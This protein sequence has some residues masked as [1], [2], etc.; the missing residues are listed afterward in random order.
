MKSL[1]VISFLFYSTILIS[2]V[3][4]IPKYASLTARAKA[5]E[6]RIEKSSGDS[7]TITC[8]PNLY[9][10]DDKTWV[11]TINSFNIKDT[12]AWIAVKSLNSGSTDTCFV[13]IVPWSANLSSLDIVNF[14][15]EKYSIIGKDNNN[16]LY[17]VYNSKLYKTEKG[18]N[19]LE[20]L[21]NFKLNN[22]EYHA[23]FLKTP[24]GSF[25]R[26]EKD[27]YFSE[28]EKNWKLDYSTPGRGIRN[29]FAYSYDSISKTV[30][31]FTHD[32]S[33]T[34]LDT[35]PHGVYRR[36][37][38]PG[39]PGKWE[40]VMS[41]YSKVQWENNRSL[42]PACRHIH[43]LSVDPYTNH[44][45]IGSGDMNQHS[46]IYY[47]EDNGNTWKHVGM[48]SQEWRILS[49]WFTERYVYWSMDT[50]IPPQKIFRVSRDVY[51]KNGF[52]PDMS[53][54]IK[55]GKTDSRLQYMILSQTSQNFTIGNNKANV[56]DIVWGNQKA[57][58]N[59]SNQVMVLNDP[60]LD[61]REL[62]AALPNNA[63]WSNIQVHDDKGDIV[64]LINSNAEGQVIDKRPRIFG[65]KERVDGSVDL[66]ELISLNN[67]IDWYSQLWPFE[68]DS[69]GNIYYQ[70]LYLKDVAN[71]GVFQ[72]KLNWK[73]NT[74]F[75]TGKIS[76]L[77]HLRKNKYSLKLQEFD[78]QLVKWQY[79]KSN[80]KWTDLSTIA[81]NDTIEVNCD[82]I[83]STYFRAIIEVGSSRTQV[84]SSYI[85]LNPD[86]NTD[87][88]VN[89]NTDTNVYYNLI[90]RKIEVNCND[91]NICPA[92][93]ILCDIT[94]KI[95]KSE[96]CNFDTNNTHFININELKSGVYIVS[97]LGKGQKRTFKV[98][99]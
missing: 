28:D 25:I 86:N 36:E 64:T 7:V 68:Q 41:F 53:A 1:L 61:Y 20:F 91:S 39:N 77:N 83:S 73:D 82:S 19:N 49:I 55:T 71:Y 56:G 22:N 65:I 34:G 60:S 66:Q 12:K 98:I 33:T 24:A 3:S 26:C 15:K 8:S 84:S 4:I 95:I 47:S 45:W 57:I 96:I 74:E 37:I 51:K 81:A 70:S 13:S 43:T 10:S 54:V 93:V 31:V 79:A 52:W 2:S 87:I 67:A 72:L 46:H 97:L 85:K 63:L 38:K 11:N 16:T 35:F 69:E 58:L 76:V 80:L 17:V 14:T 99:I 23:E 88:N 21:S 6:F 94:G 62:V 92:N 42:F 30:R 40:K 27:I 75:R 9:I 32:Y 44:I 89:N 78:G 59:D 5:L 18:L 90:T 29:S 50:N 48:G